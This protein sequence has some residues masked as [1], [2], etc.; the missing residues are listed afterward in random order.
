MPSSPYF[1]RNKPVLFFYSTLLHFVILQTFCFTSALFQDQ[2]FSILFPPFCGSPAKPLIISTSCLSLFSIFSRQSLQNNIV[3]KIRVHRVFYSGIKKS[4][5]YSQ[6]FPLYFLTFILSFSPPLS[7]TQSFLKTLQC[8]Q[9][10]SY[11]C[12]QHCK[13]STAH[14]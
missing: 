1:M 5:F 7:M 14:T 10:L 8:L 3:F 4:V 2:K 13:S 9:H 6:S 11:D 12:H